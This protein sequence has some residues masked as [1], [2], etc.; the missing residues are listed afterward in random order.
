M[1]A[2]LSASAKYDCAS[3]VEKAFFNQTLV[4]SPPVTMKFVCLQYPTFLKL[5]EILSS[6]FR[7]SDSCIESD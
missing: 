3:G 1:F 5:Y 6:S 7:G 4:I 2:D